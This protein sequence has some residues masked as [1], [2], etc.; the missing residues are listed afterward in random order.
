MTQIASPASFRS[1]LHAE[2]GALPH[3]HTAVRLGYL[4]GAGPR[5]HFVQ[6]YDDEKLLCD[7]VYEY[8][9]AGFASGAPIIII[10]TARH[11]KTFTDTLRANSFDVDHARASGQLTLLDAHET[12]AKFMRG[13]A[14]DDELFKLHVGSLVRAVRAQRHER[15]ARAYGEMVDVL[16]KP[17]IARPPFAWSRCGT[18][19]PRSKNFH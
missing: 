12:L 2:V 10:A 11:Q 18:T 1:G 16:W 19:S 5:A 3:S 15:P 7:T 8:V 6:F 14:P 13:A 4:A 17:E 9:S